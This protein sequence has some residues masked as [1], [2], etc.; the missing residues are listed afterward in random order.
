MK[1]FLKKWAPTP[2]NIMRWYASK[3]DTLHDFHATHSGTA[4]V[5]FVGM[6]IVGFLAFRADWNVL[7]GIEYAS[8]LNAYS[9]LIE[10]TI[11]A[12]LIQLFVLGNGTMVIR[13]WLHKQHNKGEHKVQFR[14]HGFLFV[15]GLFATGLLSWESDYSAKGKTLVARDNLLA[16][17][18]YAL[19]TVWQWK[20]R[21]INEVRSAYAAD[22]MRIVGLHSP[23]IAAIETEAAGIVD[24]K[25]RKGNHDRAADYRAEYDKKIRDEKD[26]LRDELKAI[27]PIYAAQEKRVYEEF[28]QRSNAIR[29]HFSEEQKR[30]QEDGVFNAM[31]TRWKNIALNIISVFLSFLVQTFVRGSNRQHRGGSPAN[32]KNDPAVL[33]RQKT[34]S[35]GGWFDWLLGGDIDDQF[36][37]DD[38]EDAPIAPINQTGGG[39]SYTPL[40]GND[41]DDQENEQNNV[42]QHPQHPT[43]LQNDN[44]PLQQQQDNTTLLQT[45]VDGAG[46]EETEFADLGNGIGLEYIEYTGQ[47]L[48]ALPGGG[49]VESNQR[50]YYRTNGGKVEILHRGMNGKNEWNGLSW[51]FSQRANRL[52]KANSTKIDAARKNNLLWAALHD[53]AIDFIS[54]RE[55]ELKKLK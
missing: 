29:L 36:E 19:D 8:S 49:T 5:M 26:N 32:P 44:D 45:V 37:A 52:N 28:E 38:Q 55:N 25:I 46:K 15:V 30:L 39:G 21:R 22:S 14:V 11:F 34:S 1:Q 20:D 51:H 13:L 31:F 2:N 18:Q 6:L 48:S 16:A 3:Q 7:Y 24:K 47:D 4:F 40:V 54:E 17:E 12:M 35:K 50:T 43:T 42:A 41:Q 53:K 10:A 23:V 27:R 9:A 33:A